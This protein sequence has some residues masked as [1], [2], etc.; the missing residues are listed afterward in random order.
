MAKT[1]LVLEGGGMRGAYTAGVLDAFLD[2]GIHFKDIIGVSAGAANA[3]SYISL[4][5]GRNKEVYRRFAP[6]DKYL[7]FKSFVKTGSFFGMRYVFY[8]VPRIHLPFDYETFK[9]SNKKL[10]IVATNFKDGTPFYKVLGDLS[11]DNEMQY[12]CASAAIPIASTVVR[13]D[14]R[15]LMDGG[16]SDSIPIAYSLKKGNAKNVVVVTRNK[17]WRAQK[18]PASNLVYLRYP[19]HRKF[20]RAVANRFDYYNKSLDMAAEQEERGDA[21]V[22]YPSRPI[23]AVRFEKDPVKLLKLYQNGYDDAI[24]KKERLLA[25]LRGSET[26]ELENTR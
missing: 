18:G 5:N 4:Q 10:T 15:K 14:G 26:V 6:D 17:G 12:L 23:E 8:E 20:A 13:V 21:I 16:A 2:M 24:D 25:F 9:N 7:S 1:G 22:F 19:F 3:I 11:D